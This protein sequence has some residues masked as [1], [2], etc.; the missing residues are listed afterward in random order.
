MLSS[1]IFISK[2]PFRVGMKRMLTT[3]NAA[4]II[5]GTKSEI[6]DIPLIIPSSVLSL[7]TTIFL[8]PIPTRIIDSMTQPSLKK[9]RMPNFT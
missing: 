4:F 7:E 1:D 3:S 5:P 2:I 9:S 6:S 8:T